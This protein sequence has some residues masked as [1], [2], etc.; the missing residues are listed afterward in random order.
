MYRDIN[1]YIYISVCLYVY[2]HIYTHISV[3][4]DDGFVGMYRDVMGFIGTYKDI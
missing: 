3:N 1:G 4:R 2:I